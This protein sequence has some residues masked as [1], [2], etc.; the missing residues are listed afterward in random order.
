VLPTDPH[1]PAP[2]PRV[3]LYVRAGCHL[4][5]V[6]AEIVRDVCA[7][8]GADWLVRDVDDVSVRAATGRDLA[9]LYSDLVPVVTVDGVRRGYWQLDADQL[10]A[11]LAADLPVAGPGQP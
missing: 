9:A 11:A 1:A 4:C 7:E 2:E 3:V 6:A 10:R 8:T 5:D